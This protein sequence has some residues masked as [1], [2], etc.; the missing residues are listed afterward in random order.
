MLLTTGGQI[1]YVLLLIIVIDDWRFKCHHGRRLAYLSQ[2]F[3]SVIVGAK[4]L[5]EMLQA[6]GDVISVLFRDAE[7]LLNLGHNTAVVWVVDLVRI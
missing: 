6:T 2:A 1:T 7:D 4:L 3:H 5:A